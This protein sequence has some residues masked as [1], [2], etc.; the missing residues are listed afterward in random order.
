M[1]VKKEK[2]EGEFSFDLH[3]I[4]VNESMLKTKNTYIKKIRESK[5]EAREQIKSLEK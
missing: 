3:R 1:P 4:Y 5:A 2:K